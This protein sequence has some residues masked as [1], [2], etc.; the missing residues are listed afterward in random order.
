MMCDGVYAE[1]VVVSPW[2]G[3]EE[4]ETSWSFEETTS[5]TETAMT[6]RAHDEVVEAEDAQ[7]PQVPLTSDN[8]AV[9]ID[10]AGTG[11]VLFIVTIN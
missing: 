2:H 11:S 4:S 5:Y 8:S 9:P 3:R 6:E 10:T 1:N 7:V